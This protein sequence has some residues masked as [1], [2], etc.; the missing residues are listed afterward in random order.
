MSQTPGP[1]RSA[2]VTCMAMAVANL[3]LAQQPGTKAPAAKAPAASAP[4][5]AP[6]AVADEEADS[7][8]AILEIEDPAFNAFVETALLKSAVSSGDPAALTDVALLLQRGEAALFRQHKAIGC[9]AILRLAIQAAAQ[10]QD[11]AALERLAAATAGLGKKDL[12]AAVE[13]ATKVAAAS[14]A[15][16]AASA[17]TDKHAPETQAAVHHFVALIDS[18]KLTGTKADL[19]AIG[20]AIKAD[21]ALDAPLK[22]ALG[23]SVQESLDELPEDQDA[24]K[25]LAKL[26][27]VSRSLTGGL[28]TYSINYTIKN[29]TNGSVSF[30]LHG[31]GKTYTLAKGKSGSYIATQKWE[32]KPYMLMFQPVDNYTPPPMAGVLTGLSLP[33]QYKTKY[34]LSNGAFY[35]RKSGAGYSLGR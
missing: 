13:A 11:K 31:S 34:T 3:A 25:A 18:V 28:G 6:A 22:A 23:K 24:D 12:A 7:D 16:S 9:D 5:A 20:D 32:V 15:A 8:P 33:K 1:W 29:L 10:R 17:L 30:S 35:I 26:S 14:R 19:Q 21:E 2:L 27:G 4:A